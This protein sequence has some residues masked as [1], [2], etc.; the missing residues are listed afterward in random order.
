MAARTDEPAAGPRA[1]QDGDIVEHDASRRLADKSRKFEERRP[2][3][4]GIRPFAVIGVRRYC[5]AAGT[6]RYGRA[7][8]SD[9]PGDRAIGVLVIHV[10]MIE[11]LDGAG[12]S[13][14]DERVVRSA[15]I[16]E[17]ALPRRLHAFGA[18]LQDLLL[19]GEPGQSIAGHIDELAV[20]SVPH[21]RDF[22][23][24]GAEVLIVFAGV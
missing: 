14:L 4:R 12:L 18:H 24:L 17:A 23:A 11:A 2:C 1:N 19:R 22:Q 16:A 10:N 13:V 8:M 3:R 6:L 20:S 5:S 15:K 21:L 7:Q 9:V